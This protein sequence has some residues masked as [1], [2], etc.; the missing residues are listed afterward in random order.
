M[1][2]RAAGDRGDANAANPQIGTDR[3]LARSIVAHGVIGVVAQAAVFSG[4]TLIW[5]AGP[6]RLVLFLAVTLVYHALLTVALVLRRGDFRIESSGELLP[7]VNLPNTL[8]YIRLSS[9]PTILF[10]VIQAQDVPA[11]LPVILPLVC[12]VFA[13]DFLD[14]MAARR[15][16]QITFVGRYLDSASDYLTIIGITIILY[17]H[18]LLPVWFLVLVLARLLLFATGMAVLAV[19]EGRAN[20]LVTFVGKMSIFALMVLYALEVARLFDVPVVGDDTVVTV[21]LYVVAAI[22]VGSMVDKAIFLARRFAAIPPRA[23]RAS[24]TDRG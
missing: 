4:I 21:V 13:T 10:L 22:V 23:H 2:T 3:S 12:I 19:R 9:L 5:A 20:P 1:P 14:G 16:G 8:T 24:G 17:L 18:A 6:R 11:T 7:R 15:L